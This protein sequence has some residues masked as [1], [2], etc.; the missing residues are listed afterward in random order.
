M[1]VFPLEVLSGLTGTVVVVVV[2]D[3]LHRRGAH[4]R[5]GR[6]VLST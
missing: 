4:N 6:V 3:H 1:R 5:E 2:V